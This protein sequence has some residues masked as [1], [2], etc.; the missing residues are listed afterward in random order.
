MTGKWHWIR[1]IDIEWACCVAIDSEVFT[2]KL[3]PEELQQI[4]GKDL[5]SSSHLSCLPLT[6]E[7]TKFHSVESNNISFRLRLV[8]M[9]LLHCLLCQGIDT[10]PIQQIIWRFKNKTFPLCCHFIIFSW[11][12]GLLP[13]RTEKHWMWMRNESTAMAK[14]KLGLFSVWY[15]N[16]L[17]ERTTLFILNIQLVMMGEWRENISQIIS[18]SDEGITCDNCVP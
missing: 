16:C 5:F 1:W 6:V 12:N 3:F 11:R 10:I 4:D 18:R 15:D 14:V 17:I 9:V 2:F 13:T 7:C 8:R